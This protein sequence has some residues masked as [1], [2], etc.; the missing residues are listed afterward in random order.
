MT[1]KIAIIDMGTNTFHLLIAAGDSNG[2]YKII[3]RERLASKIGK[4]GINEGYITEAGLSRALAA[5]HTFKETMDKHDVHETYAF[6]TSALRNASNKQQVLQQIRKETGIEARVISGELEA[7]YIYRGVRFSMELG[8]EK[9]LIVDIGGGSVECIIGNRMEIF[10][11]ES[12]EVGA[13]RLLEKYQKNDP[14]TSV[15]IDSMDIYFEERLKSLFDALAE[16][17][18]TALIG[19]SGTFDTLS[20][21]FC[22]QRDIQMNDGQTETPLTLEAFDKIYEAIINKNRSQRMQ[23]PGMIEMR[24]DMIVV[25]CCLV[26]YILSRWSFERIR[27]S[28]YSLKEGVLESLIL[29]N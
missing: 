26:R 20:E 15:E 2:Q 10:W 11:K 22:R 29:R 9:S 23:I 5:M 12:F 28:A 25:A 27:V 19:A 7:E 4:G 17:N 21:I 13:Q 16:H 24:V 3:Q 14:I 1:K 18:P 6:G 8:D